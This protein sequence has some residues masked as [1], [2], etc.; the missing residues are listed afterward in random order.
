MLAIAN[1]QL[2]GNPHATNNPVNPTPA[3]LRNPI[4]LNGGSLA[5]TGAEVTWN[6]LTA[7][8]SSQGLTTQSNAAV[9]ARLGGN[10][11]LTAGSTST[12]LTYDPNGLALDS[13]G[14][15]ISAEARLS[16]HGGTR[17]R[18]PTLSTSGAGLPGRDA[19]LR[20]ELGRQPGDCLQRHGPAEPSTSS[21]AAAR[22][23]WPPTP[24]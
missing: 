12:I 8:N 4:T 23:T 7:T 5:A 17:R 16:P 19:D 11:S 20:H 9:V 22:S 14:S 10:F 13:S 3:Y 2:N 1:D 21:A 24:R 18:Q 6:S 15:A